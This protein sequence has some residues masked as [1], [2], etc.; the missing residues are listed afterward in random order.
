MNICRLCGEE[1]N[2]LDLNTELNDRIIANWS[3]HDLIEHHTRVSINRNK[4][5]PQSIC[6]ECRAQIDGFYEFSQ[7]INRV[8]ERF[9]LPD[10]EQ[11]IGLEERL[12]QLQP[13]VEFFPETDGAK[14]RN[15]S[16][17]ETDIKESLEKESL[18]GCELRC[19]TNDNN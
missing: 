6:E 14:Y 16:D 18:V 4:L 3:Y 5:L 17:S 8:Q 9:E 2:P 7:K 1:K 11:D 10:A 12:G 15:T 13:I 19:I